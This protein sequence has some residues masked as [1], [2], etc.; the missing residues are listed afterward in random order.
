VRL[1]ERLAQ[2]VVWYQPLLVISADLPPCVVPGG[3]ADAFAAAVLEALENVVRHADAEQATVALRVADTSVAVTVADRGRG[4][5][6]A[7]PQGA[8]FGLREDL[9][10]RME[11]AG[12][13]ATVQSSPGMGTVVRLVW[14]RA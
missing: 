13:T 1:D 12:G 6:S 8:A 9:V 14:H 4:F 3:V 2:I 5:E 7:Q 10:G 11:A